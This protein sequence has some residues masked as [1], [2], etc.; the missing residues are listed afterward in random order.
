MHEILMILSNSLKNSKTCNNI[1]WKERVKARR[2]GK[3][4][5]SA[6]SDLAAGNVEISVWVTPFIVPTV[7][8]PL[9]VL[10]SRIPV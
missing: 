2:F 9:P 5:S 6:Q 7:V 3:G 1:C 4:N 10:R 8:R